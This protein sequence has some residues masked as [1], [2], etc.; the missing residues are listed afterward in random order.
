MRRPSTTE[1]RELLDSCETLVD[2]LDRGVG[3]PA[4]AVAEVARLR[5]AFDDHVRGGDPVPCA[6]IARVERRIVLANPLTAEL[7]AT[8]T[9]LRE[10]LT[11]SP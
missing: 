6:A 7:H 10:Q 9:D 5:R 1:L 3:E 4:V 11:L 8:L 2:D